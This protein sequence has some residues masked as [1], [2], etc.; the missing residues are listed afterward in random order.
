MRVTTFLNDLSIPRK[1]WG[2]SLLIVAMLMGGAAALHQAIVVEMRHGAEQIRSYDARTLDAMVWKGHA[3]TTFQCVLGTVMS[4]EPAVVQAFLARQK[5]GSAAISELQKKIT[6][7]ATTDADRAALKTIADRRAEVLQ[8]REQAL[9]MRSAGAAAPEI[10][11][12]VD[13]R[14]IPA[15]QA[16]FGGLDAYVQ[17]QQAQREAVERATTAESRQLAQF[18]AVGMA[19]IAVLGLALGALMVESIRRPL[20]EAVAALAAIAQGDLKVRPDSTRADELGELLRAMGSTV[21][22][23]RS[24]VGEVRGGVDAVSTASTQIAS[25][26]TDLRRR[27]EDQAGSLQET[28]ASMEELTATVRQNADNARAAAQLA[29]QASELA[30]R[31]GEVVG[32]VV[33]TMGQITEG[34]HVIG[35][36]VGII[37]GIAFQTNILA[38]NAAVE[39]ARAGS[40]GRGFAVVASEVRSL[41]QR[42]AQAAREIK[43]VIAESATRIEGGAALVSQAGGTMRDIVAQVRR[44]SDIVDEITAASVEQAAGIEQVGRAVSQLDAVT[45]RNAAA[46]EDSGSAAAHMRQLAARLESTVSVFDLGAA[47]A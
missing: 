44:V 19:V 40:Q 27:T 22:R 17:L 7:E 24:V 10:Q 32:K 29:V 9:R 35:E 42:S 26:S 23:L 31:G 15:V 28:A 37:D 20:R 18:G 3:E 47:A 38:L 13:T 45:Q 2:I 41:A 14:L 39:A 6:E 30:Q 4:S 25:G 33:D 5:A 11:A 16:Y 8:L 21:E 46:V 1:I 43:G 34:A 12:Y 36:M